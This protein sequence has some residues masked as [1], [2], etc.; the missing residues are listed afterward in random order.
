M[1]IKAKR[2]SVGTAASKKARLSRPEISKVVAC[3]HGDL[4][5]LIFVPLQIRS[6]I[7]FKPADWTF[8]ST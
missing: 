5:N 7:F 1:R 8:A 4:I 6:S 2:S 3:F